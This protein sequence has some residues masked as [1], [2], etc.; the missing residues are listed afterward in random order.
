MSRVAI[1]GAGVGGLATAIG[2]QRR[3]HQV[4]VFERAPAATQVGAGLSLFGNAFAALDQIG[5]GD[6]VRAVSGPQH[7]LK[8]G[9][10]RR[11]GRWLATIPPDAVRELRLVHRADLHRVLLDALDDG[12]VLF[13]REVGEEPEGYDVVVAADGLRS[14]TRRGWPGDPGLRYSGYTSWRGV[15]SGPVDLRGEAGESLGRGERVGLAPLPDGRVYWFGAVTLPQGTTYPDEYAEVRRRFGGWHAPI[16]SVL[17]ATDPAAVVRTDIHDL[18]R[19]LPTFRRGTTVLLGDAAHAM[20]PD[21]GQGAAMAL[22]DAATLS[23]LLTTLSVEEA[24]DVYDRERR[25]RTQAIA[26]RAR[27]LGRLLQSRSP[28]RDLALRFTPA[29]VAAR[30]L[31]VVQHFTLPVTGGDGVRS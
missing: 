8:A 28:L 20:T 12:T 17:E 19:P 7:H 15:T 16:R 9:Q 29:P 22:E 26:R 21:L 14:R 25:P 2:L 27:A 23:H 3:G 30:Q 31:R 6:A 5:V 4:T 10:R 18:A 24:L 11:D 1:I 13:D